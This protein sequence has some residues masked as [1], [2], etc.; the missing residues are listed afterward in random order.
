MIGDDVVTRAERDEF[1]ALP[2][3]ATTLDVLDNDSDAA[4]DGLTIIRV[5]ESA[6][7]TITIVDGTAA[8]GTERQMLAYEP[9][10]GFFGTDEFVYEIR[11]ADGVEDSGTVVV[12]V[13]RFSDIN[14]NGLNDFEECD[15][16]DLT[17]ETGIHGSGV[18][19]VSTAA[20]ALLAG[21]GLWRRRRSSPGAAR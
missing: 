11:D 6:D 8:D 9:E 19:R 18:G 4:G 21:V 16:T 13:L 12:N 15:C 14:G 3:R 5:A 7:A 1:D 10:P 17:L 20:L 2:G